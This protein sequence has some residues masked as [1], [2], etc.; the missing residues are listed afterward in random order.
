MSSECHIGPSNDVVAW[1]KIT[2]AREQV[3]Q[4]DFQNK[5][6]SRWT[7]TSCIVSEVPLLNLL[8]S[9]CD[10]VTCDWIVQRAYR[11]SK[12]LS[13]AKSQPHNN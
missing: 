4:W 7:G 12:S 11:Q 3:V 1:Y 6:R 13:F 10:F 8:T 9:V 5:G 2:H